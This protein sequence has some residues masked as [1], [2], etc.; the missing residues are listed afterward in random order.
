MEVAQ[1]AREAPQAPG[2][3]GVRRLFLRLLAIVYLTAFSSLAFQVE[4]LVGSKGILPVARLLEWLR[5]QAGAERYWL[6]PTLCWLDSS[7][8]F[9]LFLCWGGVCLSVLLLAGIAPLPIL[10]L[11]WAFYLS[12][13]TAGQIF[14]GYQWDALL[15]EAGLL[16]ILLAPAG[17]RPRA[18]A[19][20]AA[21]AP[22]L[23][24]LRWLLFRLMLSSGAVKLLSGDETWRSLTALRVHYETQPLPTWVGWYVHQLPGW[25]HTLSTAGMFAIELAVPFLIFA[26]RRSR[27]IA[28]ASLVSFQLL[29]AVT[30]N[31]AFFNLLTVALCVLLLDDGA[32]PARWRGVLAAESVEPAPRRWYAW[33]LAALGGTH[34][35]LSLVVMGQ[36]LGWRLPW[37]RPVTAVL[38]AVSPFASVNRYGLFAV[39]TTSRPEISVEGSDDGITWRP[40]LFRWKAGPVDRR[41]AFVAPHQPRLDWQM[42]FAALG[43]CESNAWFV[44]FLLRLQEGSP[45]VTKL[46][47]GNPFPDAPPRWIR[48]NLDDYRF[49]DPATRR[50]TGAWWRRE[51]KGV[52]C[53]EFG[54]L[55]GPD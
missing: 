29:I 24:L 54:P 43:R 19:H 37:P 16:A 4:G 11:L 13:A 55:A 28:C 42:W 41:P 15:L 8:A 53:Q 23:W 2:V 45:P 46:L 35:L 18:D 38:E 32:L 47:A 3:G 48:T 40:Y 22:C 31:Y 7:D 51:P 25:F 49:T 1:Q 26:G 27:R 9:L 10:V 33:P 39:M 34:F 36:T 17:L 50:A 21:P 12:L 5:S 52:Y 14:L 30:G 20:P 6:V 44:R